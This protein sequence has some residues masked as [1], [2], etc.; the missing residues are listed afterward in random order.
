MQPHLVL[1]IDVHERALLEH[2]DDLRVRVRVGVRVRVRARVR[3]RVRVRVERVD[4]HPH[5]AP[6]IV[7]LLA[8]AEVLERILHL[9][10]GR[11]SGKAQGRLREGSGKAQERLRKGSGK[12]QGRLRE[13]S[14]NAGT[15]HLLNGRDRLWRADRRPCLR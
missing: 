10:Y 13:G 11:D 9:R 6:G 1:M 7:V 8:H 4:D 5:A 2:V 15:L 14:G 12:V 3:V